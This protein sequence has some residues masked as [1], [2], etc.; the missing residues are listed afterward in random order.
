MLDILL[1]KV[2]LSTIPMLDIAVL[3][4]SSCAAIRCLCW[5]HHKQ[6]Q[7]CQPTACYGNCNTPHALTNILIHLQFP[8]SHQARALSTG[9]G[10]WYTQKGKHGTAASWTQHLCGNNLTFLC[11]FTYGFRHYYSAKPAW[12]LYRSGQTYINCKVAPFLVP[13]GAMHTSHT[14]TVV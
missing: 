12:D 8:A 9:P 14:S 10:I 6:M 7:A 4:S 1:I 3:C 11:Y 13:P 2:L 5:Q